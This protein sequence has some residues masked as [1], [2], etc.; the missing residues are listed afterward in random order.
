MEYPGTE[1]GAM[2]QGKNYYRW[3]LREFRPHLGRRILEVG[4]GIGT[5]SAHLLAETVEELVVLLEPAA[6]LFPVL[7]RRFGGN[8]RV[9]ILRAPVE[10]MGEALR[11]VRFDSVV[12]VNVLEHIADDHAALRTMAGLLR[13]GGTLLLFVPALPGLYG[14]LDAAFGHVRRYRREELAGKLEAAGLR[15]RRVWYVNLPG[16]LGWFLIG[17]VFRWPTL[18]P[19]AVRVYDRLAI[20][21]IARIERLIPPPWGQSLLAIAERRA[22]QGGREG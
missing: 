15:V 5:F 4:A 14:S 8:G 21:V 19:G 17:R 3:I 7:E 11:D 16:A 6:N 1:F 9:R 2:A 20:P 18:R 12:S 10:K 22:S 13:P